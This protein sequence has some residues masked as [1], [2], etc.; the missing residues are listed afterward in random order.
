[1]INKR[2]VIEAPVEK[3]WAALT[4]QTEIERWGAG[5]ASMDEAVG[6]EF[7]LWSGDIHGKNIEVEINIKLV[8]EWY[9]GDWESPS[10]VTFRLTE[11][12]DA[13]IL[14]L[15]HDNVPSDE[16]AEIDAGWDIHYL[17]KIEEYLENRT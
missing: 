15:T 12:D 16:V 10:T 9:S 5:P 1:M 7:F 6:S 14:E 4:N 2:Y 13:T 11:Q 3:V 8:Q 17:G